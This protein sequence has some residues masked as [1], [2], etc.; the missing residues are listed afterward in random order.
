LLEVVEK[1]LLDLGAS[2]RLSIISSRRGSKILNNDDLVLWLADGLL[3]TQLLLVKIV[4]LHGIHVL[5]VGPLGGIIF[6]EVSH[7]L[8][9]PVHLIDGVN[10]EGWLL[11]VLPIGDIQVGLGRRRVFSQIGE[12]EGCIIVPVDY[13]AFVPVLN[14]DNIGRGAIKVSWID[15]I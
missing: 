15:E 12:G 11:L 1:E 13:V 10:Y 5:L 14:L 6:I 2:G 4:V 7:V 9:R 3:V 8:L